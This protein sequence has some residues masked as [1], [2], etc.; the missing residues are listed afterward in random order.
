MYKGL[1]SVKRKQQEKKY[2]DAEDTTQEA[3]QRPRSR[4]ASLVESLYES[5]ILS[6]E[7]E[8]S[9]KVKE[10]EDCHWENKKQMSAFSRHGKNLQLA[11]LLIEKQTTTA[12]KFIK[13][14]F[15]RKECIHYVH[16]DTEYNA[17]LP[18]ENPCYCGAE[19]DAHREHS[20]NSMSLITRI[21]FTTEKEEST[22]VN[23][24]ETSVGDS[25][26]ELICPPV[27]E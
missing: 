5:A 8:K 13:N 17:K 27:Q 23:S 25:L 19:K 3:P 9:E 18:R 6:M 7:E 22:D 24:I 26:S 1:L 12:V 20:K 15:T 14:N 16:Q 11:N 21:D 10:T 4:R 2:E